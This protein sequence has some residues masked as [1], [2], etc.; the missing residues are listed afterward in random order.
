MWWFECCRSKGWS[1]SISS[2]GEPFLS[3]I[4]AGSGRRGLPGFFRSTIQFCKM[5]AF[6]PKNLC[7]TSVTIYPVLMWSSRR[8]SCDSLT[9][10]RSL[11]IGC[12][13][14]GGSGTVSSGGCNMSFLDQPDSSTPPGCIVYSHTKCTFDQ[15]RSHSAVWSS[16]IPSSMASDASCKVLFL[17]SSTAYASESCLW[18]L[19]SPC[20]ISRYKHLLKFFQ[21][22]KIFFIPSK[23]C[24]IM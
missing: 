16:P 5:S 6:L 14:S 12:W 1:R 20:V 18:T 11:N 7:G 19:Q 22:F 23:R 24:L 17:T 21:L 8:V 2:F 10:I 3:F 15:F 4:S 13:S 9:C